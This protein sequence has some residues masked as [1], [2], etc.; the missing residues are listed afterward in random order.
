MQLLACLGWVIPAGGGYLVLLPVQILDECSS[1][2][3][4]SRIRGIC[5]VPAPMGKGETDQLTSLEV[6]ESC[7]GLL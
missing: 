3:S 2:H 7:A 5:F 4:F 1:H 6:L